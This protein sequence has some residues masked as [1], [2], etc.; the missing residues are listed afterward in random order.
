MLDQQND[1]LHKADGNQQN[2]NN[3]ELQTEQQE[4]NTV[5]DQKEESIQIE[6][7]DSEKSDQNQ[8]VIDEI[9][10]SNAEESEDETLSE[11]HDIPM[12][13]YES[14]TMEA[15]TQELQKLMDSGK[16]S[17]IKDHVEEIRKEFTSKYNDF[18][19]DKKEQFA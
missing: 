7:S 3:Q 2:E 9:E 8:K 16:I 4:Q 10:H 5:A 14:M 12:L 1:N 19:D 11:R 17:S 15:L 6:H 18:I 13:D